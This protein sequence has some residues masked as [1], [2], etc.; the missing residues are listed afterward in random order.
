MGRSTMPGIY[1]DNSGN[2]CVDKV[3]KATRLRERF[4]TNYS[5]AENWLVLQMDKLRKAKI[6]G[7]RQ[8]YTFNEAAAKYLI[9]HQDK[10]SIETEII[11]L[12]GVMPYIGNLALDQIHD[13][14]L[15]PY[16]SKRKEDGK[17]NK[18][19][20]LALG[21]VRRILNLATRSWRDDSGLTWLE[22]SPLITMLPLI[23]HQR[24]P[25]PITWGEQ[26][27]LLPALPDHLARMALFDLHTGARDAVVCGLKWEME[28]KIPELGISVFDVPRENVKGRKRGRILVCNSV[29]QSIIESVRGQHP[30]YTFVY[31]GGKNQPYRPIE[32][33]NNTAWQNSRKKAKLSDL[34]VHDLRHTV[35]MRLREAGVREETISDILWHTRR[36]VTAHYSM[37]QI[38]EIHEALEKIK[39][40]SNRWNKSLAMI[41]REAQGEIAVRPPKVPTQRKIG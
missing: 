36:G 31:K 37:G 4:G 19:I 16:V 12:K 3:Y 29:A 5:E 38:V 30:E 28:I 35:G 25:M 24:E 6:F 9:D 40:E 41:A 33:M 14:T 22:A 23:G 20:N 27:R 11:L 1:R 2:W 10:V 13:G 8:R 7:Q 17:A 34:H 32:T 26:R 15:A 21:V 18:T 39:D